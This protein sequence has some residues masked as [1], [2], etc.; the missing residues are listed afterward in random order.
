MWAPFNETIYAARTM[1][2]AERRDRGWHRGMARPPARAACLA[3]YD[4]KRLAVA[5]FAE[6]H[7]RI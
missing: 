2:R 5:T 1:G 6:V 7:S 4:R 3:T